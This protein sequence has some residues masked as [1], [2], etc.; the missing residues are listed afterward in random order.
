[1]AMSD[2]HKA[3]LA[4]GRRESR[5]IKG[6][7]ELLGSR[8]PG[9]PITR[10]SLQ[11]KLDNLGEKIAAE[12]D[13]LKKVDLVQQRIE[14]RQTLGRMSGSVDIA[15]LESGFVEAARS[16]S[17]RKGI[18]YSAWR[19]IGVPADVLRKAGIPRTRRTG[20]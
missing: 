18:S 5:M 7:L 17:Q 3:A 15:A 10:E 14:A 8:R 6:Y 12:D 9:R 20:N 1:M 11:R 19:Q 13:L 4:Q 2:E 16:Y